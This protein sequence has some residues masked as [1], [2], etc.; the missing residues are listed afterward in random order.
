MV[1]KLTSMVFPWKFKC[2]TTYSYKDAT[3]KHFTGKC[4]Y[5]TGDNLI[6]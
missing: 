5:C 4:M 6:H 3:P 2:R 1:P